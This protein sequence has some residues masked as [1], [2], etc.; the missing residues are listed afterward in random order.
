MDKLFGSQLGSFLRDSFCVAI[1]KR[2][3]FILKVF[4]PQYF[5]PQLLASKSTVYVLWPKI[6]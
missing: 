1:R 3:K 5:G 4:W 6:I 2:L